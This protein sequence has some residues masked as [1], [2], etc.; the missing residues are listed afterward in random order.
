MNSTRIK[1]G[2]GE[3]QTTLHDKP[4]VVQFSCIK[5]SLTSEDREVKFDKF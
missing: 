4:T 3:M 5:P 2:Y 1:V